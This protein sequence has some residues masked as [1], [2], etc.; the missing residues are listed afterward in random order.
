MSES[1]FFIENVLKPSSYFRKVLALFAPY[2]PVLDV[3]GKIPKDASGQLESYR[4]RSGFIGPIRKKLFGEKRYGLN[5]TNTDLFQRT[6]GSPEVISKL[7]WGLTVKNKS[8]V[9]CDISGGRVF[10]CS[11][12]YVGST[13]IKTFLDEL[14]NVEIIDSY[15]EV[16]EN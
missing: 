2:C 4:E 5:S 6:I 11:S 12:T 14:V 13:Q 16:N 1:N 8:L 9:L 7:N 10:L 15:E 3:W